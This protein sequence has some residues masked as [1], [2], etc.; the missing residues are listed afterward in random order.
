MRTHRSKKSF[1]K[2]ENINPCSPLAKI[3][4]FKPLPN[5]P[6]TPSVAMTALAASMYDILVSLTW[7]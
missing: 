1:H 3:L 6:I 4:V 5:S 2:I 7:R